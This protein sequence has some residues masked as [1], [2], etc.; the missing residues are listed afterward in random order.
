MSGRRKFL[1]GAGLGLAALAG[2]GWLAR[3]DDGPRHAALRVISGRD[4][5]GNYFADAGIAEPDYPVEGIR[6]PGAGAP[7]E[8]EALSNGHL[9]LGSMSEI[10][11]LFVKEK[12]TILRI[13]A[14]QQTDVNNQVILLP[15]DSSIR[16]V[17]ELAG[18]RI[19]YARSTTAHYFLAQVLREQGLDFSGVRVSALA[20]EDAYA[21]FQN[22]NLDAW[23]IWGVYG[24]R[25]R[26]VLGA[27][28]LLTASG[29]LSGNLLLVSQTRALQD[30]ATRARLADYVGRIQRM[31]DWAERHPAAWARRSALLTGVPEE[32]FLTQVSEQSQPTRVVPVSQAA[33]ASQQKV[34]DFLHAEG[35]ITDDTPVDYLWARDVSFG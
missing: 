30:A 19:G 28:V 15:R 29:Y 23:V 31:W 26:R 5:P 27:R 35:I 9:D 24:L 14:V 32:D 1:Y 2:A 7:L 18:K 16:D 12:N 10:P 20:V 11:P 13:V 21:A 17:R 3:R 8:V 6:F 22:G 34:A 4:T 33:I 25:A